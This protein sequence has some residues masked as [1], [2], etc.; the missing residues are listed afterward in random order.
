MVEGARHSLCVNQC[1]R[2]RVH[3]PVKGMAK[4]GAKMAAAIRG[5]VVD[6]R[7]EAGHHQ[8]FSVDPRFSLPPLCLVLEHLTQRTRRNAGKIGEFCSKRSCRPKEKRCQIAEI[9]LSALR[10]P[11]RALFS[12]AAIFAKL[13]RRRGPRRL[14]AA[15]STR[16][17]WWEISA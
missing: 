5:T 1:S 13:S 9:L 3:V 6:F 8:L 16:P 4:A 14:E 7:A 10:V 17:C 2:E 15:R 11:P 12:L